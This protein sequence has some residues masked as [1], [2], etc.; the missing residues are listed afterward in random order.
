MDFFHRFLDAL[1]SHESR[2]VTQSVSHSL[3][4]GQFLAKTTF[5]F[6]DQDQE[7][8]SRIKVIKG[9]GDQGSIGLRINRIKVNKDHGDQ[10]SR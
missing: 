7:L 9:Q 4:Q 2:Y 5:V 8:R 3:T 1:A 10:E 6:K